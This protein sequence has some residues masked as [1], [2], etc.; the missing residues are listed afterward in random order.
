M[1]KSRMLTRQKSLDVQEDAIKIIEKYCCEK[2]R[3]STLI[4]GS[5]LPHELES[6]SA[7][8]ES[9]QAAAPISMLAVPFVNRMSYFPSQ[10]RIDNRLTNVFLA[11]STVEYRTPASSPLQ[12]SELF[13]TPIKEEIK[14]VVDL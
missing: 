9:F 14:Y 4:V 8:P 11:Q 2:Y 12:V 3:K 1:A 10:H 7:T 6:T 13:H 5:S